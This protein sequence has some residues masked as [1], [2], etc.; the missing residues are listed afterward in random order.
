MPG[1]CGT[2]DQ[3]GR[4]RVPIMRPVACR[5]RPEEVGSQSAGAEWSDVSMF[6]SQV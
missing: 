1:S 4:Q 5:V 3:V 2:A 6:Q